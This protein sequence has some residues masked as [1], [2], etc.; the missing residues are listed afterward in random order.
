LVIGGL[1]L[2]FALVVV[3]RFVMIRPLRTIDGEI[4]TIQAKLD[5]LHK[6]RRDYFQADDQLQLVAKR[7]FADDTDQ[8]SARAGEVLTK[9]I[10][11]SG[12]SD[13]E[14]A[15]LPVGPRRLRGA[16]E[17]GWSVQGEGPLSKVVSL[18]FL[19]EQSPYVH[20]VENLVLSP[21]HKQGQVNVYFRY[22]TLVLS[23]SPEVPTTPLPPP[24]LD[25]PGRRRYELIVQ[26]NVFSPFT[27]PTPA[28]APTPQ[29]SAPALPGPETFRVVSLSEWQGNQEV[30]VR[31]LNR[32]E[33]KVYKTGDQLAGGAVVMVDYRALPMPGHPGLMS[34]S[35]V[36]LR[37]GTEYWAIERGQTLAEKYRLTREQLPEQLAKN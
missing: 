34:Y 31:D 33:T 1:L 27:A 2:V 37:V 19:M 20:R 5:K 9:M 36:I 12:L 28:A 16:N 7:T 10:L 6:Q 3:F 25:T 11:A 18:L 24:G 30:A 15:R 22:L 23:P 14:F 17:I 26:R 4:S 13:S 35:R 32:K 21:S 29:P 8:A